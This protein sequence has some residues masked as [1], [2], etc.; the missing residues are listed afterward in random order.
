MAPDM[1]ARRDAFL[2][3]TDE[4][5]PI[6]TLKWLVTWINEAREYDW[7]Q[8]DTKSDAEAKCERL[9]RDRLAGVIYNLDAQS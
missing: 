2:R 3:I 9:S 4:R 8:Y 6:V 1:Q 7:S 5:P